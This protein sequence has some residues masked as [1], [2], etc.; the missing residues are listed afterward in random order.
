MPKQYA[1]TNL[2]KLY[3][4]RDAAVEQFG[5]GSPE[6][7]T[8]DLAIQK[9]TTDTDT[10]K[11]SLFASNIEKTL[12][13]LSTDIL[14]QYSGPTGALKLKRDQA[15]DLAGHPP[16]N[17]LAY[18]KALGATGIAV[19]QIRQ[20]LGDSSSESA[21]KNL[22]KLANPSS[23]GTSPKAAKQQLDSTLKILS[24]ELETYTGALKSTK[25]HGG[26]Q[27]KVTPVSKMST[28]DIEREIAERE[29]K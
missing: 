25:E 17:Y 27:T 10:R 3:R 4:E 29:G 24:N 7:Q 21:H 11:R 13:G 6:A 16:E 18:K 2:G 12:K 8:Y 26:N 9:A 15:A 19:G 1:P 20:F 23:W 5:E 28:V 22:E 14:T